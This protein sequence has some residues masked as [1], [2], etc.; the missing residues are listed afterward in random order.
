MDA[1]EISQARAICYAVQQ[2]ISCVF[3]FLTIVLSSKENTCKGRACMYYHNELKER[4]EKL[5]SQG[6]SARKTG[7]IKY[8]P[9]KS[10]IKWV[11]FWQ[12]ACHWHWASGKHSFFTPRFQMQQEVT[13]NVLPE[14]TGFELESVDQFWEMLCNFTNMYVCLQT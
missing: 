5:K 2:M 4:G 8:F 10:W 11:E 14:P 13:L 3:T 9:E 12:G 1:Y 7:L 6:F